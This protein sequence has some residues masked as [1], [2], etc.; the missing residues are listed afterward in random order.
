[1]TLPR[2]GADEDIQPSRLPDREL[3]LLLSHSIGLQKAQECVSDAILGLG[4]SP[5]A[6][7]KEDALAVLERLALQPGIIGV[8]ARFAKSRVHLRWSQRPP[9]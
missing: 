7:S 9:R 1:V 4:L 3:V 8:T 2:P 6:L 5:V